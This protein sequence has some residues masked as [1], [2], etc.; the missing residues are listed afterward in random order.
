MIKD[1]G[2]DEFGDFT[3]IHIADYHHPCAGNP[4]STNQAVVEGTTFPLLNTALF[5][6]GHAIFDGDDD[7][8]DGTDEE[9][10][11]D[12]DADDGDDDD[13]DDDEDDDYDDEMLPQNYIKWDNEI[14]LFR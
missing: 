10:E 1:G 5:C 4:F 2:H 3:T 6:V 14:N 13:D 12:D 11:Y 7:D 8:D 9:D